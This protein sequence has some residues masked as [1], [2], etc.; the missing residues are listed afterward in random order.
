MHFQKPI[1]EL[2]EQ[3]SLS[4][5]FELSSDLLCIAGFDGY[6]K[7]VNPALCKLLGYSNK[8]LLDQ[9]IN[10]FIHPDDRILTE[11]HRE[12][13]R[14]GKPLLN[15]E[16]RYLS[17]DGKTVWFSWTSMPVH[18]RK[19]VY[20]IAKNITY[21][22]KHESERNQLLTEATEINQRLKQLN[23]TTAHDLRSPVNNLLAVFSM[24]DTENIKDEET[25]E[26]IGIL[27]SASENLKN[28]L[29]NY[30][31]DLQSNDML[32]IQKKE[33]DLKVV[34]NKVTDS[35][36]SLLKDANAKIITNFDSFKTINFS[37]NYLESIFL[38]LITNSVKY[39]HPDRNPEIILSTSFKDETKQL[40]F[41]DNGQGFD[42]NN[43]QEKVFGLHQKFH[44]HKDSK[45]IGLYLVYN[46]MTNLGGHISVESAINIG[47]TFTLTFSD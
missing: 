23:Y 15:F 45:G 35:L 13:I 18:N 26:F 19:L 21:I 32:Q 34:L 33:L 44:D 31:D 2:D 27:R 8:E 5:F 38:N 1:N 9:P 28:T 16:N 42:S 20:A 40:T 12:N 43:N 4:P 3:Y 22:K 41:S 14:N 46:H 7:K 37:Q 10:T 47:T 24:L 30:V 17:K 11:K 36:G 6:F 39:A 25:L 29:D